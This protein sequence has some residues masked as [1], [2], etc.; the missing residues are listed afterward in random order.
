MAGPPSQAGR[1]KPRKPPKKIRI[2]ATTPAAAPPAAAA[3]APSEQ[4]SRRGRGRGRGKGRGRGRGRGGGRA[5]T[6]HGAVFFTGN[7]PP[8]VASKKKAASSKSAPSASS[9]AKGSKSRATKTVTKMESTEEIVV[10]EMDVGVGGA[11]LVD[12]PE[13]TK[14]KASRPVKM[15][16][17]QETTTR[18]TSST[19]ESMVDTYDSDSSEEGQATAAN[20]ANV[21]IPP[22]ELPFPVA[23]L[24]VGI[25]AS[26]LDSERPV[27]YS[28]QQQ[29]E[30]KKEK[31]EPLLM[32]IQ[33]DAPL[34]SP[35][36]DWTD[37]KLRQDERDSW[38]IFQF[39]TRLPELKST[40]VPDAVT[41]DN[42]SSSQTPDTVQS[43]PA[44]VATPSTVTSTFDNALSRAFPGRLGKIVVYKS[45]KTEL[46]MGGD[47]GTPEVCGVKCTILCCCR[48]VAT[49]DSQSPLFRFE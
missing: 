29:Q 5:P 19:F 9:A 10:G 31:N 41:S 43:M 28:F 34:V 20:Q 39:P 32:E 36:V 38:F 49:Y 46:V 16:A 30:S 13:Q 14:K 12:T 6:P 3:P 33:K 40:A 35:F 25:G 24:P 15:E 7:A 2:G 1:F 18:K 48:D 8:N 42:P 44:G 23:P 27:M 47:N 11:E 22:T 17:E 4:S 26:S 45:G 37:A 21:S